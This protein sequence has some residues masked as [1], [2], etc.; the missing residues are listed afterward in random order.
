M[1]NNYLGKNSSND[2]GKINS[3]SIANSAQNEMPT[4]SASG[5]A[6]VAKI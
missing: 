4:F 6:N 5:N 1:I 3:R 2:F